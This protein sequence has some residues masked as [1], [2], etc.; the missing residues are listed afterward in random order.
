MLH[1]KHLTL[2]R[3]D[4]RKNAAITEIAEII[5]ESTHRMQN[6]QDVS[7]LFKFESHPLY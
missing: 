5:G 3:L 7:A 4:M 6:S 1:K 2:I